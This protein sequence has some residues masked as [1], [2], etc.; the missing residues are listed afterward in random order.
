[1]L[2]LHRFLHYIEQNELF[3]ATDKILLAVSGGKDSVVMTHLF[4]E[5][6]FNFGI[7]HCNFTL[8]GEESDEDERFCRLLAE[9]LNK[10]FFSKTFDTGRFAK[11]EKISIQMAARELRYDWLEELRRSNGY[12]YIALAHHQS[13]TTETILLNLTRGT[14][15]AGLHGILP[16]RDRLIR[17][18]LFL[19]REEIDQLVNDCGLIYREDSSNRSS[20]YA[21]NKIRLEVIPKLKE[22]NPNLEDTFRRNS[23]R[24]AELESFLELHVTRLREE[25]LQNQPSGDIEIELERLQALYPR[26]MLLYELFKPYHFS[27]SVL[28]DLVNAWDGQ[29]G[30][31]FESPSHRLFLDRKKLILTEIK[32]YVTDECLID[33]NIA[34]LQFK[35][36]KIIIRAAELPNTFITNGN[37]A[38]FDEALLQFPLKLRHWKEGDVFKPF[39]MKGKKKLSDFFIGLKLSVL[40]KKS[41]KVLEN[42][43][44]DILWVLGYRTDDRYKIT[45]H[46]KKVLIFEKLNTHDN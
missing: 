36:T 3:K 24:F 14:G 25:L 19:S 31:L 26:N 9:N 17:P 8:R 43:N 37:R 15:I 5:T 16:K 23:H 34:E 2:P 10:P 42:G 39:G 20:K 4:N 12:D 30:K 32:N 46:T 41:V 33:K 28:S 6:T 27:E 29:P 35:N 18:L 22:L 13:D 7:A 45:S 21:R 38:Y 11:H 40:E 1:M 44:G